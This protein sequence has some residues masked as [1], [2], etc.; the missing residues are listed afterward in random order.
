MPFKRRQ[1]G[2]AGS[3]REL[4]APTSS[5]PSSPSPQRFVSKP[6]G[7]GLQRA[8]IP[9]R[10]LPSSSSHGR[11]AEDD[12]A[13]RLREDDDAL[14]EVIM[15]VDVKDKGTVG[16]CFYIA[17]QEKLHFMEDAKLGGLE[18]VETRTSSVKRTCSLY[19]NQNY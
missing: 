11:L 7:R 4:L 12:E 9:P 6:S 1:N 19:Q 16:C 5:V 8:G 18:T 2:L 13:V 10:S 14:N 3:S 15:A 17:R